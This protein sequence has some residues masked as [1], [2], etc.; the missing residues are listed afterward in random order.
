MTIPTDPSDRILGFF[1]ETYSSLPFHNEQHLAN[2]PST[3]MLKYEVLDEAD[4]QFT[5]ILKCDHQ[6]PMGFSRG[7]AEEDD[8]D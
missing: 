3:R 4:F 7:P 5:A 6:R 1:R 8:D 2:C